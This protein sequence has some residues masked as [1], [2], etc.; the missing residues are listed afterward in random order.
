MTLIASCYNIRMPNSPV[1]WNLRNLNDE[2]NQI[3]KRCPKK[4]SSKII[5]HSA[6][7]QRLQKRDF[8]HVQ[9]IMIYRLH[10]NNGAVGTF[11]PSINKK[12]HNS[13]NGYEY[14]RVANIKATMEHNLLAQRNSLGCIFV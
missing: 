3:S 8:L 6:L 4:S 10:F 2:K 9:S 1:A 12:R 14:V 5:H 11:Y 7:K 13:M